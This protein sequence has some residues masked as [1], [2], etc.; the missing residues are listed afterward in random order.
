M[1]VFIILK[2]FGGF[3]NQCTLSKTKPYKKILKI[4]FE[5][6]VLDS[7]RQAVVKENLTKIQ[8]TPNV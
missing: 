1:L 5:S 4:S 6:Q 3:E 2:Y 8:K 7:W